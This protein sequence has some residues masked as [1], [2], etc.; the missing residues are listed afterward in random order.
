MHF[1][2]ESSSSS[3]LWLLLLLLLTF[4]LGCCCC[5]HTAT[6]F[7][8]GVIIIIIVI[9][10][11]IGD[12]SSKVINRGIIRACISCSLRNSIGFA[13]SCHFQWQ[14]LMMPWFIPLDVP[15]LDIFMIVVLHYDVHVT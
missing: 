9:T 15:T 5:C 12:G 3:L 8:I 13:T 1:L 14:F 7:I 6:I 2:L 11:I 4:L 10:F